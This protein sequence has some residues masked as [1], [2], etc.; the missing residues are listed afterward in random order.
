MYKKCINMNYKVNG[1]EI[2]LV[3]T[4]AIVTKK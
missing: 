3:S 2:N 1:S 4:C